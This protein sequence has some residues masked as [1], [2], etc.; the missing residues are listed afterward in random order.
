MRRFRELLPRRTCVNGQVHGGSTTDSACASP[1]SRK[2]LLDVQEVCENNDCTLFRACH[3]SG[4]V[5]ALL[6]TEQWNGQVRGG[7]T[8]DSACASPSSR[9]HLL[10]VQEV[11]ANDCTLFR[12]CHASGCVRALL[13]TGMQLVC[14][15][16]VHRVTRTSVNSLLCCANTSV[17]GRH[18][19][20]DV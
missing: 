14:A 5:R 3:A 1:S 10:D 15:A 4:C 2:R 7:S 6:G 16:E 19:F 8:T 17:C 13:G 11:C 9:K 12:A 20:T 18:L